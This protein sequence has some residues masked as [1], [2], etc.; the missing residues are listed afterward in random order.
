MKGVILGSAPGADIIDITHMVA[1]QNVHQ[2]A[3]ILAR[4]SP[5]YP[6]GTVHVVVV[7]PGVGTDRRPIAAKI[8]DQYFVAPDN[9]VLTPVLERAE[10]ADQDVTIVHLDNPYFWLPVISNVF[11]GRDIFSPVGAHLITGATL[12]ELGTP[13]D[14]PMRIHQPRPTRT[15]NGLRGEIVYIDH[16]GNIRTN[17]HKDDAAHLGDVWVKMCGVE[18]EGL[19]ST[20]GDQEPGTLVSLYGSNNYLIAAVVNGSASERLK[21]RIGDLVELEP[22]E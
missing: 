19:V 17:I 7:D 20:F 9:G 4:H 15:E 12:E 10:Q 3:L 14:D 16:F 22:R 1:P 18:I 5:Y 13:I 8:G 6:S 21:P 11:H 2:A